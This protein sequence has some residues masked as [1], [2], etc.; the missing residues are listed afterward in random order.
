MTTTDP[1]QRLALIA[2]LAAVW[3][4]WG[5]TY[6]GMAFAVETLPPLPM[7]GLRFTL[8]GGLLLAFLRWRG[9]P[10]PDGRDLI[11]AAVVG[12]FLLGGGNA[13]VNFTVAA[14]PSGFVALIISATPLWLT[15]FTWMAGGTRP[16]PRIWAGIVLGMAGVA[17]L[18][19]PKLDGSAPL[20]A[21]C[22][23]IVASQLWAVGSLISRRNPPR[24]NLLMTSAVQ[25]VLGGLLLCLAG[26]AHGDWARVDLAAASAASITA[27]I[28]LTLIGSLVGYVAYSWLLRHTQPAVA[29]S[30]AY[31]NPVVACI[32][33]WLLR[34]EA[35]SP[36]TLVGAGI[37]IAA[38]AL[39]TTAPLPKAPMKV[40]P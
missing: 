6:L 16:A 5:S 12:A 30:Y 10:W 31:V 32:L 40:Q 3:L 11:V 36:T 19:G 34:D 39:V 35:L 33:G 18:I 38:V 2:A 23:T 8:A 15:L 37:V 9:V 4:I 22:T 1:P 26:W 28:Y 20:W 25:Q 7:A 13:P 29:T 27:F 14:L 21:I 17:V 24:G